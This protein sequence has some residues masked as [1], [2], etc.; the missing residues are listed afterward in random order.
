MKNFKVI[1]QADKYPTEYY[2]QASNIATAAARAIREW[3]KRF[4]GKK[5][6]NELKI[7]IIK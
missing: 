6:G 7:K 5:F 2:I 4:K 3:H 1:I